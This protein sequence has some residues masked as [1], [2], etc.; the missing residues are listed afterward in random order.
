M[1]WRDWGGGHDAESFEGSCRKGARHALLMR[2]GGRKHKKRELMDK[3]YPRPASKL[4]PAHPCFP[5]LFPLLGEPSALPRFTP[6]TFLYNRFLNRKNTGKPVNNSPP[7]GSAQTPIPEP[8]WSPYLHF[9][10]ARGCWDEE[11][12]RKRILALPRPLGH[13]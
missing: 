13:C 12:R 10:R 3:R 6:T 7:G 11:G 9:E 8:R 2:P 4:T 1:A 5:G